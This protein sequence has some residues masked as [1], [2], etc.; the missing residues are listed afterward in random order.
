VGATISESRVVAQASKATPAR[1]TPNVAHGHSPASGGAAC[2]TPARARAPTA[3]PTAIE[4]ARN[5]ATLTALSRAWRERLS[6][7]TRD[8][9]RHAS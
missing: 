6:S 2:A 7:G 3:P 4:S 8:T 9:D 5:R 1:L